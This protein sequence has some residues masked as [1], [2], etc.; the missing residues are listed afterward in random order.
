MSRRQWVEVKS[1]KWNLEVGG[2]FETS[3]RPPIRS[4]A[5]KSRRL[6]GH[7]LLRKLSF[8]RGGY[9]HL[10]ID[11]IPSSEE[12]IKLPHRR[13]SISHHRSGKDGGRIQINEGRSGDQPGS[14]A[15][16][17]RAEAEDLPTKGTGK[18]RRIILMTVFNTEGD[19]MS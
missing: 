5:E 3:D 2:Q 4:V 9:Q 18:W 10:T 15:R 6:I 12:G 1:I 16:V 8:P 7:C 19:R 13:R 11:F 14:G 17:R